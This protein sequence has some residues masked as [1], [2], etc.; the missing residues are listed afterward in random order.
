MNRIFF[1]ISFLFLSLIS[2]PS[3][4]GEGIVFVDLQKVIDSSKAAQ[5]AEA[6][7]QEKLTAFQEVIAKKKAEF[8]ER[9]ED[10]QKRSSVL[11]EEVLKKERDALVAELK[12][13][14][15]RLQEKS[16]ELDK[17]FN[18]A[19]RQIRTSVD[20]IVDKLAKDNDYVAVLPKSQAI[21]SSSKYEI[22]EKVI[23]LLNKELPKI[24][25]N[26]K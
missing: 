26:Q 21:Y 4:A 9:S 18:N 10:L 23:E 6:E 13:S 17:I 8:Q 5:K 19:Q 25:L 2:N 12:T 1:V 22:T 24:D 14:E 20:K 7:I 3:F 16:Q 11:S 15:M